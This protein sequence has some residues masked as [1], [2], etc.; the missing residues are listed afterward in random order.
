MGGGW[1]ERIGKVDLRGEVK[2][3]VF[4]DDS[5]IECDNL[6]FDDLRAMF[7]RLRI[8]SVWTFPF[9]RSKGGLHQ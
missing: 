8:P 1:R 5:W 2:V 7:A 4:P 9:L 6:L 3:E